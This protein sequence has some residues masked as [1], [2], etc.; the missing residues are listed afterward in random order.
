LTVATAV[1]EVDVALSPVEVAEEQIKDQEKQ[2]VFG[3]IPNFYVSYDH[4][5]VP[6][7]SKQKFRLAWKMTADPVT[8]GLIGAIAGVQ[9]AANSF[10]GYGREPRATPS[11]SVPP[12]PTL[13]PV[14]S[15]EAPSCRRS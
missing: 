13:F 11:A 9:Q 3:V 7:N 14:R 12:M 1:T 2:R 4:N 10:S 5:P 8:F 6:L 15:S